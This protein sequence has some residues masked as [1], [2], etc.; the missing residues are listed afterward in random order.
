M[1]R[2]FVF[3]AI[4][5]LALIAALTPTVAGEYRA[6]EVLV[7][8]P[9]TRAT[10][11]AGGT[12][13]GYMTLVNRGDSAD[14][15]VAARSPAAER[16]ELHTHTMDGGVMRMRP[17]EAINLG[18]GETVSLQPGG[19]HVMFVG[20]ARPFRPGEPVSLTLE[21]EDAGSVAVQLPVAPPG[22]TEPPAE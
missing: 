2:T 21:F 19:L 5:L 4:G 17:V 6:G 12:G 8:D 22:A 20:T 7:I 11:S 16:V 3:V 9:W 18:P 13:A 1:H 14:R 15:L 10:A